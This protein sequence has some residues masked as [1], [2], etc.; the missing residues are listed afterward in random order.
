MFSIHQKGFWENETIEGHCFDGALCD[1]LGR[2]LLYRGV[3]TVVDLGCGPG[4][5]VRGF[6]D[7][8]L[9]AEG[10]DGNPHTHAI[11][12][13]LLGNDNPCRVCD[14]S[15]PLHLGKRFDYVVSL[16]VGEHIP[17]EYEQVFLE[18]VTRH[19]IRGVVISWAIEGQ[20]GD[21]HVNCRNNEY[22]IGK[23]IELG[24]REDLPAK[25]YLRRYASLSW[26]KNTLLA[27]VP[28]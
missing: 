20:G 13:E 25:R 28:I 17:Q 8:G 7:R 23:M 10:Y 26:M 6:R 19:A 27:F 14:L 5:Y 4:W 18:N 3:N 11:S 15:A 9:Y 2:L 1:V 12:A 16:E 22:V 24:F 21:G